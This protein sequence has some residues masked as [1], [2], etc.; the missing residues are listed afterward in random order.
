MAKR[1][2][3]TLVDVVRACVSLKKQERRITPSTVQLEVGRG[4]VMTIGR[5]LKYLALL[6]PS[7]PPVRGGVGSEKMVS[8]GADCPLRIIDH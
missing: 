8:L 2:G 1:D 7:Y 6:D 3:I 5:I 4:G